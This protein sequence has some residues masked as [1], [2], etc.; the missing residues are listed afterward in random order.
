MSDSNEEDNDVDDID[1]EEE[2]GEDEQAD[3]IIEDDHNLPFGEDLLY[4]KFRLEGG[5][6]I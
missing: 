3:D 2:I 4:N 5:E 6:A 1:D